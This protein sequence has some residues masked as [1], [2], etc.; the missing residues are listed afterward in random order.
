MAQKDKKQRKIKITIYGA[1]RNNKFSSTLLLHLRKEEFT[2]GRYII[3]DEAQ[4]RQIIDVIRDLQELTDKEEG[5]HA[6]G[7]Y[8]YKNII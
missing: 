8:M 3:D 6:K 1:D 2:D 7:S 4:I 5:Q